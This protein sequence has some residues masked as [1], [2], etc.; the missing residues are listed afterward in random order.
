VADPKH[1][2]PAA[3]RSWRDTFFR[4]YF[5]SLSGVKIAL[6]E[7][8]FRCLCQY[9]N[10]KPERKYAKLLEELR[11]PELLAILKLIRPAGA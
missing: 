9:G 5:S 11:V 8:A 3:E 4:F 1:I 7:L 10:V 2:V 6:N